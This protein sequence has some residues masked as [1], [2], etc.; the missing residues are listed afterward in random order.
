MTLCPRSRRHLLPT[1]PR[2]REMERIAQSVGVKD[3][4]H[5]W[6]TATAK[7]PAAKK[8]EI[9][10]QRG[11]IVSAV[12][13]ASSAALREQTQ[14]RSFYF[15]L[16]A[17]TGVM[18]CAAI[19][20]GVMAWRNPSMLPLCFEPTM[21][22]ETVVVCPTGQSRP[23]PAQQD[24][25][26]PPQDVDDAIDATVS[27]SDMVLVEVIGATAATVAAAAAI[28]RTRGSS[29][30][31]GV[32]M[33]LAALKLP[34]GAAT[35][36]LGLLLMRG[37]FIP[38]L[39][40]LDS[41]AQIVS[42]AIVF[43]Y[44]QQL[45]T[46]FIDQQGTPSSTACAAGPRVR[47]ARSRRPTPVDRSHPLGTRVEGGSACGRELGRVRRYAR[48]RHPGRASSPLHS[49]AGAVSEEPPG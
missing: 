7:T 6:T 12:R 3:A 8:N 4:D 14:V 15:V 21:G 40:A 42:W 26:T 10:N 25:V 49:G 29:E 1:D 22:D 5:P 23:L 37:E 11:T 44:A 35:A 30:P 41:P 38:G 32:P 18:T 13:G 16:I 17:V 31:Y 46:R 28:R 19:G 33:A 27:P 39:S 34:T 45:F 9:A 36:V 47:L 2:R 24:G 43:G 48:G 20:L